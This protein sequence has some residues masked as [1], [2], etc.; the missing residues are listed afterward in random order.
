MTLPASAP[1]WVSDGRDRL[2]QSAT[3]A[4]TLGI[5]AAGFFY[6]RAV[7]GTA[8]PFV[9]LEGSSVKIAIAGNGSTY[10]SGV[11]RGILAVDAST[12]T[13]GTIEGYMA[14]IGEEVCGQLTDGLF[15]HGLE[16]ERTSAP[17]PG[18]W[19]VHD[20][21][22]PEPAQTTLRTIAFTIHWGDG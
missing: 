8:A 19:A 4:T 3:L 11:I 1:S 2:L 13:D 9:V 22:Q 14:L 15:F 5:A 18:F 20:S 10:R 7:A 17:G 21:G 12:V 16:F 6:P